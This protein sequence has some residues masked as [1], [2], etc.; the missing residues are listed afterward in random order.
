LNADTDSDGLRDGTEDL[1]KN[2]VVDDDETNPLDSDTD[3]GGVNDGSEINVHGTDPLDPIDDATADPDQDGLQNGRE[4]ATG[5]DWLDA[6][7]DD[8]FIIDSEEVGTSVYPTDTDGDGLIDALDDDS[9]NDT[10][11]DIDEAGDEDLTTPA[12][13]TD[14]DNISDFR[15]LDSDNGGISDEVEVT[16]HGTNQL[17]ELDD[18]RG[19]LEEGG[20]ITGG[21]D[22]CSST[23][24]SASFS[25]LGLGLVT[26]LAWFRR[27][28]AVPVKVSNG[29]CK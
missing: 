24:A 1:N 28:E 17:D 21:C 19:W 4:W 3:D 23:T 25:W 13:D 27:R 29:R 15:D 2:G 14:G 18:G 12:V 7:S 11:L 26:L 10:I 22:G 8:D 5:T 20:R 6:D 9:D 16:L